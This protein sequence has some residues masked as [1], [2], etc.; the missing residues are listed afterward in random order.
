LVGDLRLEP[1]ETD[2]SIRQIRGPG[3]DEL[4]R[5]LD[6]AAAVAA[7]LGQ[8]HVGAEHVWLALIGDVGGIAGQVL[9]EGNG[10]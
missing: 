10:D 3:P 9:R 7:R 4:R 8:S 1:D 2:A 6:E 5:V